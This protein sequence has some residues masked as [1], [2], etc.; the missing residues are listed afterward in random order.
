M[1]SP[2]YEKNTTANKE[3][4]SYGSFAAIG[5]EAAKSPTTCIPADY[6]RTVLI[7]KMTL[8]RVEGRTA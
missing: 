6:E 7:R 4:A 8:L 5:T 2:A 3:E 1:Q